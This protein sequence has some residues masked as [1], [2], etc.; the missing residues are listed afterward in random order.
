SLT[1]RRAAFRVPAPSPE[2]G[3]GTRRI[4]LEKWCTPRE[5][6]PATAGSCFQF[7]GMKLDAQ[8]PNSWLRRPVLYPVELGVQDLYCAR[9]HFWYNV[10]KR[11]SGSYFALSAW[12]AVPLYTRSNSTSSMKLDE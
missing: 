10:G 7:K 5:D 3:V 1:V 12:N 11:P 9:T 6:S 4:G 2:A 8:T